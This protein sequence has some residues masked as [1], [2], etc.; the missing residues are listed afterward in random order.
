[1][2]CPLP[3]PPPLPPQLDDTFLTT[4]WEED[5]E[6][7]GGGGGGHGEE[8][9]EDGR[10]SAAHEAAAST[11]CADEAEA[12][13]GNSGGGEDGGDGSGSVSAAAAA[14]DGARGSSNARAKPAKQ[15]AVSESPRFYINVYRVRPELPPAVWG[16]RGALDLAELGLPHAC[17]GT[18]DEELDRLE[19]Q[20]D[21]AKASVQSFF[22]LARWELRIARLHSQHR[23]SGW[24]ENV[25][26]RALATLHQLK[27]LHP[28]AQLSA[29]SP[30]ESLTRSEPAQ[31]ALLL[32]EAGE[33]LLPVDPSKRKRKILNSKG[34][35]QEADLLG[36]IAEFC[37]NMLERLDQGAPTTQPVDDV[38]ATASALEKLALVYA[39]EE[40][41]RSYE[42][43][44]KAERTWVMAERSQADPGG[45]VVR[46][47]L[48]QQQARLYLKLRKFD[49]ARVLLEQAVEVQERIYAD[50]DLDAGAA[51]VLSMLA[52]AQCAL[53]NC[54]DAVKAARRA[55]QIYGKALG[56]DS[57]HPYVAATL[58]TLA[59]ALMKSGEHEEAERL[60]IQALAIRKRLHIQARAVG[61]SVDVVASL[62]CLA[63]LYQKMY[64]LEDARLRLEEAAKIQK[65][66]VQRICTGE[67]CIE[68]ADMLCNLAEVT[69]ASEKI[70]DAAG[71]VK[72]ALDVRDPENRDLEELAD[73]DCRATR[74]VFRL[75]E[76]YLDVGQYEEAAKLAEVAMKILDTRRLDK[77]DPYYAAS[78]STLA[79]AHQKMGGLGSNRWFASALKEFEAVKDTH[80]PAVAVASYNLACWLERTESSD[81]PLALYQRCLDIQEVTLGL[82]HRKAAATVAA[83]ARLLTR[84]GRN[85]DARELTER[86]LA[87]VLAASGQRG[88][89][90]R[91]S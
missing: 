16:R 66:L 49:D 59:Q 70:S 46:A 39:D 91:A 63:S 4:F 24:M 62:T 44:K 41:D 7:G 18:F 64:R 17:I 57:G 27:H 72:Q 10:G 53:G 42:A 9:P 86:Q 71:I 78:I 30:G 13:G 1:M 67:S 34:L 50:Y 33:L 56:P 11:A 22:I 58:S 55:L 45:F 8:Q 5:A 87:A 21:V 40:F 82:A 73:F 85:D 19:R 74:L 68:F 28:D 32:A 3:L 47:S 20:R 88:G 84:L 35:E 81:R 43:L 29:L 80:H 36:T 61:T 38:L 76:V 2:N 54:G 25:L 90:A 65:R 60:H 23:G 77:S 69:C 75:A 12:E 48:R 31:T 14:P 6:G 79:S 52:E 89:R 37:N 15:K 26:D 51:G 83:M